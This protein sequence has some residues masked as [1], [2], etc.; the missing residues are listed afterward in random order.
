[1]LA[2]HPHPDTDMLSGPPSDD[3]DVETGEDAPLESFSDD[4][5]PG[6]T[7]LEVRRGADPQG[8]DWGAVHTGRDDYRIIRDRDYRRFHSYFNLLEDT[9]AAAEAARAHATAAVEVPTRV[10]LDFFF[11]FL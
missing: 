10:S 9:G 2:S 5:E 4:D 8:I 7:D 1:V 11:R 3:E 6:T